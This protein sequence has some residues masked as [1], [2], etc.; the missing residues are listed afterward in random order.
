MVVAAMRPLR[1]LW[2]P[3]DGEY[4]CSGVL[5]GELDLPCTA[6]AVLEFDQA[7]WGIYPKQ[8]PPSKGRHCF[9]IFDSE[10]WYACDERSG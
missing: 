2:A 3:G 7:A 1:T 4:N 5:L 10:L 6:R 8:I 9:L